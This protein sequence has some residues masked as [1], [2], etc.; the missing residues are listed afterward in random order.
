MFVQTQSWSVF[1]F[2][3]KAGSCR[4]PNGDERHKSGARVC[5]QKAEARFSSSSL[6]SAG[7]WR[8]DTPDF[9]E[10]VGAPVQQ[11]YHLMN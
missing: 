11:A 1:L 5:R 3:M 9:K 4:T 10:L 2:K 8:E 6:P 7:Y